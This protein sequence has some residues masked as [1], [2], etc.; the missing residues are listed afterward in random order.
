MLRTLS[1]S[2]T[3]RRNDWLLTIL[4]DENTSS[5]MTAA[6]VAVAVDEVD[7]ND[8]DDDGGGSIRSRSKNA[9]LR[10]KSTLQTDNRMALAGCWNV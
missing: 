8:D 9:T 6:V 5:D 3:I 7:N 1:I 2:S 4:E 10:D